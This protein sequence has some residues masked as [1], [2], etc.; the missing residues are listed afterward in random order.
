MTFRNEL[1]LSIAGLTLVPV[2]L[3]AILTIDRTH[4]ALYE[5][6][7]TTS[8]DYAYSLARRPVEY[9]ETQMDEAVS[10]AK[11]PRLSAPPEQA[12]A[13]LRQMAVAHPEMAFF[14][15]SDIGGRVYASSDPGVIGEQLVGDLLE[16]ASVGEIALAKTTVDER[17]K[18]PLLHIHVRVAD[19]LA[20]RRQVVMTSAL[21][22]D[23]VT[24]R[25]SNLLIRGRA[26]SESNHLMLTDANGVVIYCYDKQDIFREDLVKLGMRSAIRASKRES[27][28]LLETS[29]HGKRSLSAYLPLDVGRGRAKVPQ[30]W[31]AVLHQDEQ[32]VFRPAAIVERQ[33]AWFS[34]IIASILIA[35]A[36]YFDGRLGAP[37]RK[38][39]EATK[40]FGEGRL[41]ERVDIAQRGEVG[42]VAKAFNK[43]AGQI[44]TMAD[45]LTFQRRKAEAA[46][47]AKS[48]FLANMSHELRTPL[49]GVV[50]MAQ[51]LQTTDMD[52]EQQDYAETLLLSATLLLNVINDVLDYSRVE[53]GKFA[54]AMSDVDPAA[55]LE[56]AGKLFAHRMAQKGIEFEVAD[57][58]DVPTK[59]RADNDRLAQILRNLL[60]NA[61]K[62]T[63]SGSI[64][65]FVSLSRGESGQRFVKF[66][67]RDSGIGMTQAQKDSVFEAFVQA[68]PSTTRKYGGTGLGLA[69]SAGL[70]EAMNGRI[71]VFSELGKG[72]EFWI[73]LPAVDAKAE[74]ENSDT[75]A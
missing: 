62:F 34:L 25:L 20:G 15:L 16:G 69:I 33:F 47:Q 30:R 36:F 48:M 71:G 13:T 53:S 75:S 68:D 12:A 74:E 65:L 73:E 9:V 40:R 54:V 41:S 10:L 17:L 67:V 14:A 51:L 59:V 19:S 37:L 18:I 52:A 45:T 39:A 43:M 61:L 24:S 50:G 60:G 57:L 21:R 56:E 4:R 27:G 31:L 2:A 3:M 44:E 72:S 32:E 22:W 46:T 5:L 6:I 8:L 42:Q 66:A 49:N 7:G 1:V 55:I 58:R 38:V 11:D 63:D 23:E 64:Q 35:F 26:E 28:Y 70:T 29:E